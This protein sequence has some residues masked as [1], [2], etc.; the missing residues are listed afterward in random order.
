MAVMQQ[1]HCDVPYS[2]PV[3][4]NIQAWSV[5]LLLVSYVTIIAFVAVM[6]NLAL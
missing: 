2:L 4:T 1:H 3:R 5:V 6:H